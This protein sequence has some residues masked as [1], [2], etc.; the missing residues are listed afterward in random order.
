MSD[1]L[2]M[3]PGGHFCLAFADPGE[4]R[5]SGV[6]YLRQ[7][8]ARGERVLYVAD[9]SEAE[10]AGVRAELAG[11]PDAVEVVS[12][13][14]IYGAG[15]VVDP[16][17]QVRTYVDATAAAL[18]AGFTGLRVAAD[19]TMLVRSPAQREAFARYEQGID[20]YIAGNP[21]SAVCAYDRRV[22]GPAAIAELACV[23]PSGSAGA[24]PFHFFA[25]PGVSAAL[26]GEVDRTGRELLARTL[27]RADPEPVGGDI[28]VDAARVEFL[29]HRALMLLNG[30]AEREARQLL[31]QDAPTTTRRLVG[32]LGLSC[33]RTVRAA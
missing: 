13:R 17:A 31:L 12:V 3:G 33:I 28:V 8:L 27:D 32:L 6:A 20:R 30:L 22:L 10:P 23:H 16:V 4:F 25:E 26:S 29:D 21:F 2:G 1:P 19:V 24:A 5:R 18:A 7:G 9:T 11:G 15:A 14:S